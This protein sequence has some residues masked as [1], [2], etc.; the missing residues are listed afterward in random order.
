MRQKKIDKRRC[1]IRRKKK[2]WFVEDS[3]S[4]SI[5]DKKDAGERERKW[6]QIEMGKG[7]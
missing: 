3:I 1:I 4:K 7:K 6:M 2:K 5:G